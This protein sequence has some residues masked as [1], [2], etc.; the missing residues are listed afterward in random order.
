MGRPR[1]PVGTYGEI[2]T[3]Q[4]ASG[5]FRAETLFRDPDGVLRPVKRN[6]ATK[7]A[8][9]RAL[10]QALTDR[11]YAIK[12][13]LSPQSLFRDAAPLWLEEVR[14]RRRGTTF[15]T[16]RRHLNHRVLP[17]FAELTLRECD[18]VTLV[19]NF[20][21]RLEDEEKLAANT[22]R[23][24]RNVLSGILAFAAQRGAIPRNPV[25]DA[26]R[27][28]GGASPARALTATE[29]VDFLA[30]LDADERA[31]EDDLPDLVRYMLG[32]GVRLGEALGLRWFRVDLDEGIAVHGDN[33]VTVTGKGLMLEQPKTEAGYRV[34]PLPDFVLM[35]LRMR[36]PGPEYGNDPVFPNAFGTWRDRN[37]TGRS[38]RKFRKATNYE[39]VTSHVFRKT[40]I[41]IMDQQ[42]LSARSI[43]GYVGHAR[44]S[45]T[46]DTYMD[47][48]PED[49]QAS[50][51]IDRA[52]RPKRPAIPE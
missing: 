18:D 3:Y 12:G 25:R 9:E 7:P 23:S 35:M 52:Y 21:R 40:A 24:C 1:T 14:R 37:N 34:L 32:S 20:L 43:A 50:D 22:V 41:T 31:V 38:L 36:Y 30:K 17:A 44:P 33:L 51:A 16:Y 46:Q 8:A 29:R 42:G 49:R 47:K 26:G 45:I 19:H 27:I 11:Q 28:E 10:K 13:A 6:G 5:K 4:Q 2:R 15:D 39:W 48:R